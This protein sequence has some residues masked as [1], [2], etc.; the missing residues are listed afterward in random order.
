MITASVDMNAVREQV[1]NLLV[2]QKEINDRISNEIL[3]LMRGWGRTNKEIKESLE[4]VLDERLKE[5]EMDKI[6]YKKCVI[7]CLMSKYNM[8]LDETV[9]LM[10]DSSFEEMIRKSPEEVVHD[11][12]EFWAERIYEEHK[13]RHVN[14]NEGL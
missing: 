9:R 5:W 6:I 1:S 7:A 4:Y 12:V 10:S 13:E 8:Q 14:E 11:P 3:E 2:V